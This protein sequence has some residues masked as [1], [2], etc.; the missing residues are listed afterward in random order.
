MPNSF[1]FDNPFGNTPGSSLAISGR[2]AGL[3]LLAVDDLG[4]KLT[5]G[6]RAHTHAFLIP[7]TQVEAFMA[8]A[9]KPVTLEIEREDGTDVFEQLWIRHVVSGEDA[10][11]VRI[12]VSDRRW[13]W[14]RK[15][16]GPLRF[17]M[18]R[19][20]GL[21]RITSQIPTPELQPV[22]PDV[23]FWKD[24]LDPRTKKPWTALRM[25]ARVIHEAMKAEYEYRSLGNHQEYLRLVGFDRKAVGELSV[26]DFEIDDPAP[27]AVNRAVGHLPDLAPFVDAKGN[28]CLKHRS[29]GGELSVV[30]SMKPFVYA[31]GHPQHVGMKHEMPRRVAVLFTGELE[32]RFDAIETQTSVD[33]DAR[34]L[35]NVILVPDRVGITI[36]GIHYPQGSPVPMDTYL[37]AIGAPPGTVAGGSAWDANDWKRFIREASVPF[38]DLWTPLGLLGSIDPENDWAARITAIR[39]HWRRTYQLPKRW[40]DRCLSILPYRIGTADPV[41][42]TRVP[43]MAWSDYSVIGTARFYLKRMA[44]GVDGAMHAIN[45]E[46]YPTGDPGPNGVSKFNGQQY[47]APV[48]VQLL[49][50]DMGLIRFDYEID[51]GRIFEDVL[52]SQIVG[53]VT[54]NLRDQGLLRSLPGQP[55]HAMQIAFNGQVEGTDE[56][57]ALSADHKVA[58]ILTLIPGAPNDARQLFRVEVDLDSATGVPGAVRFMTGNPQGPVQEVRVGMHGAR[59]RVAWS[60]DQYK[61]I[62]QVFGV[63][64]ALPQSIP[65]SL[66]LNLSPPGAQEINVAS[67]SAV[68]RAIA[69]RVFASYSPR[70]TGG[71][72]TKLNPKIEPLGWISEVD[73][74]FGP[75]GATTSISFPDGD[76]PVLDFLALL[77]PSERAALLHEVQPR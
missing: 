11:T 12:V 41:N 14:E 66:V 58:V 54:G 39:A 60:D 22:N 70:Y 59:A 48:R 6:T 23:A 3:E 13:F 29:A 5:E 76:L 34:L 32:G 61:A 71:A 24:T 36:N 75:S 28:I 25:M 51:E 46:G 2:L 20:I 30:Q 10:Y 9:G 37:G 27:S 42:G 1:G 72:T 31:G 21:R 55:A 17:N 15:H 56:V 63:G 73:H 7:L 40:V 26:Q 64:N 44:A 52:P 77:P 69:G 49:D 16:V 65:S 43:A 74:R 47:P 8:N 45:I 68:A 4:W 50:R 38:L 57:P 33:E 19:T 35:T 67:L 62:E 18:R 53:G